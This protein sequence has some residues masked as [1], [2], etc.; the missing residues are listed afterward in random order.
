MDWMDA[1][2]LA[3]VVLGLG[4]DY[5]SD[6]VEKALWEKFE[7]SFEQFHQIAEAL[8]PLTIPAVTALGGETCCGFVKDGAFIAKMKAPNLNSTT[9]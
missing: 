6:K 2:E 3:A 5:D 1:E 9:G 4:D 8:M 7:V